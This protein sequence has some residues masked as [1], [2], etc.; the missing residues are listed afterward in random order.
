M[1]KYAL[2]CN[3]CDQHFE[4]WF[5]DSAAY[6]KQARKGEIVCPMCTS[7]NVEK[8]IMAPNIA[9]RSN[10]KTEMSPAQVEAEARRFLMGVRKQVEENCDYVG[11]EFAKEARKIHKGE[12]EERGIY[13][14]ATREEREALEEEGID[15]VAIP[16][17]PASDA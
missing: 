4:G 1:I 8:A 9:T 7:A 2:R 17:L 16:W 13:G 15:A 11:P 14:E 6:D 5:A 3:D 10:R 12:A